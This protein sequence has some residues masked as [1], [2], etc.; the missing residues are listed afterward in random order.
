MV[1]NAANQFLNRQD[2]FFFLFVKLYLFMYD[3]R[4]VNIH[5][6][7]KISSRKMNA[8]NFRCTIRFASLSLIAVELMTL[9][10]HLLAS[11]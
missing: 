2:V 3:M 8:A 6:A 7:S 11:I 10:F 5:G 1:I 4:E 9:H